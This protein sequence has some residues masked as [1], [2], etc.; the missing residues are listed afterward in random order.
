M[1]ERRQTSLAAFLR[2]LGICRETC[3]SYFCPFDPPRGSNAHLTGDG[4]GASFGRDSYGGA[5]KERR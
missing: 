2:F 3:R 5:K 4:H 1:E